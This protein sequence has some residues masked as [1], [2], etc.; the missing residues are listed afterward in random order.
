MT[1]GTGSKRSPEL[2]AVDK[3]ETSVRRLRNELGIDRRSVKRSEAAGVKIRRSQKAQAILDQQAD[4]Y[5]EMADL[6]PGLA[7]VW[8]AYGIVAEDLPECHQERF[9][10]DLTEQADHVQPIRER[11]QQFGML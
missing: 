7:A 5:A 3:A 1:T 9:R 4:R 10:R 6:M 8:A 11:L 2:V